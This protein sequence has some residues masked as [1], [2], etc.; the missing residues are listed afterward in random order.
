MASSLIFVAMDSATRDTFHVE[1]LAT[2]EIEKDGIP[3]CVV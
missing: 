1:N 3:L 2:L